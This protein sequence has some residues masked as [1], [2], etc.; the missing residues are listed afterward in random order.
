MKHQAEE[1]VFEEKM[2]SS[3]VLERPLRTQQS[4]YLI[5][6]TAE[7]KEDASNKIN[8][9]ERTKIDIAKRLCGI[10]F[11]ASRQVAQ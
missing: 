6:Y 7:E 9:T 4:A 3:K 11:D 5:P 8:A 1:K 10:V 2:G